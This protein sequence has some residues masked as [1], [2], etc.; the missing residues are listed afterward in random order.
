M[1][2]DRIHTPHT[3]SPE[4][5]SHLFPDLPRNEVWQADL[6]SITAD[7]LWWDRVPKPAGRQRSTLHIRAGTIGHLPTQAEIEQA[8][9]DFKHLQDQYPSWGKPRLSSSAK[10]VVAAT[11]IWP[12]RRLTLE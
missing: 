4:F 1:T 11:R 7:G 5:G 3:G 6:D 9:Q 8:K 12:D 10:P 2:T